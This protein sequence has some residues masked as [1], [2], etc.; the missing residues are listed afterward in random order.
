MNIKKNDMVKVISGNSKGKTGKVLRTF[1][2]TQRVII[3]GVNIVH[4]HRRPTQTNPQGSISRQEAPVHVS[5]VM[6]LDPKSNA[7]TR[8]S[9][10]AVT[11][12]KTGKTKYM[13]SSAKSKEMID[14]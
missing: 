7:A 11:D 10:T 13:R 12:E 4:R 9:K 3:E 6:I 5:N 8:I 1:R 2:A 14:K